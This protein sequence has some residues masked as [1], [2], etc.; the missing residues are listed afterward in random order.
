MFELILTFKTRKYRGNLT[1]WQYHIYR[2]YRKYVYPKMLILDNRL[3][4][5]SAAIKILQKEGGK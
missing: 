4:E 2:L 1:L 5:L 3:E